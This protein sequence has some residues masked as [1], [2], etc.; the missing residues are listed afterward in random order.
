MDRA[1][2]LDTTVMLVDDPV[3]RVDNTGLMSWGLEGPVPFLD[4][5]LVE[6]GGQLPPG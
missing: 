2:R 4:H 5:E 1:L 6:T 3:K